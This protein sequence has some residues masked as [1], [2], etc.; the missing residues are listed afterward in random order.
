[1]ATLFVDKVDPQ[2]GT[3]LEIG[4]SGDTIALGSGAT[5]TIAVNTPN[6]M[7]ERTS[8]LSI[9][10]NAETQVV[11]N[12][13][14]VDSANAYDTSTGYFTCPSGQA[15]TY[16]VGG[17]VES[18][19]AS[20]GEF[21]IGF[22][23]ENTSGSDVTTTYSPGDTWLNFAVQKSLYMSKCVYLP[24]GFKVSMRLYTNSS[25]IQI[26]GRS[27]FQGFKLIGTSGQV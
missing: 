10:Q 6:W 18:S 2:S 8:N 17:G 3:N 5:Q 22:R 9:N 27:H 14:I 13:E 23:I 21:H 24:E 20:T 25:G 12:G 4:S 19:S 15:G 11:F 26:T 7:V 1:M 16:W